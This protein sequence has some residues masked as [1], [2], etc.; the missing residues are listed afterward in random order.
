MRWVLGRNSVYPNN[1]L[2]DPDADLVTDTERISS[3]PARG[4]TWLPLAD[5]W[6]TSWASLGRPCH[7]GR[8][9]HEGPGVA[10]WSPNVPLGHPGS[11]V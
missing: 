1:K 8:R 3:L 4:C 10:P 2:F 7:S 5:I 11:W 6:V 9:T